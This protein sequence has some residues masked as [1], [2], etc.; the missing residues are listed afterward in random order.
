MWS[1]I[2]DTSI[3]LHAKHIVPLETVERRLG[4]G[5]NIQFWEDVVWVGI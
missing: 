3:D 1:K 5:A 4:D 2:V